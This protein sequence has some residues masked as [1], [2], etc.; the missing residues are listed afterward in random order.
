MAKGGFEVLWLD[1]RLKKAPE[2]GAFLD[3]CSR[4]FDAA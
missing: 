3:A 4:L 2:L 1:R